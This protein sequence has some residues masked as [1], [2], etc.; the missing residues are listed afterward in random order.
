MCNYQLS[1]QD[2]TGGVGAGKTSGQGYGGTGLWKMSS[3][4]QWNITVKTLSARLSSARI[5]THTQD[6]GIHRAAVKARTNAHRRSYTKQGFGLILPTPP[7]FPL[8]CNTAGMSHSYGRLRGWVP[9]LPRHPPELI[10]WYYSHEIT[11]RR[12]RSTTLAPETLTFHDCRSAST[13]QLTSR[14]LRL[15]PASPQTASHCVRQRSR[16]MDCHIPLG[17]L[18]ETAVIQ[19]LIAGHPIPSRKCFLPS[20]WRKSSMGDSHEQRKGLGLWSQA[21]HVFNPPFVS[22]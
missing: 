8:C 13:A 21:D 4:G 5:C 10:P 14:P 9:P 6:P 17:V 19:V 22:N 3:Q 11:P 2:G 18:K 12:P 1:T 20:A 7:C 15:M 16:Q